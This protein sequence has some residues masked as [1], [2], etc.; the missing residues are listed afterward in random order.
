MHL[1]VCRQLQRISLVLLL[2]ISLFAGTC[3]RGYKKIEEE[4]ARKAAAAIRT[5]NLIKS[6]KG[7]KYTEVRRQFDNGLSF[8]PVGY[9]LIPEWKISFPSGDSVNIYS[10]KKNK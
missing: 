6:I 2:F 1:F 10:P 3:N 9:Q 7:I 4:N 8:S 5:K